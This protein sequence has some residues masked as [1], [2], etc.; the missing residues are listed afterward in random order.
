VRE[1]IYLSDRKLAQFLP[2][3]R[4]LQRW[5]RIAVRTPVVDASWEPAADDRKERQRQLAR[6]VAQIEMTASWFS[7]PVATPGQWIQFEAPLNCLV[8]ERNRGLLFLLDRPA[9]TPDY[10]SGGALRLL[11]HGS[12]A[13]LAATVHPAPV[14][15]PTTEVEVDFG[16]D[17]SGPA[18][19]T[20]DTVGVLLSLLGAQSSPATDRHQAPDGPV[21]RHLPDAVAA[22]VAAMDARVYPETAAWM[23]GYARVTVTLDTPTRYV[24][25]TPLYVEYTTPPNPVLRTEK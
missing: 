7:D 4:Q 18:P 17:M 2:S 19:F 5:P 12:A 25:A 10:P 14:A 9:P 23:T 24:I 13:H 21:L 16:P 3:L 22:L 8:P 6:V 1:L 15:T 11:L 20:V